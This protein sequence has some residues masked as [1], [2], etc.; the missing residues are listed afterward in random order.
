MYDVCFYHALGAPF[1]SQK[2]R[3]K[4]KRERERKG[5][6]FGRFLPIRL[7]YCKTDGRLSGGGWV[8]LV[9]AALVLL[10][11]TAPRSRW[12][13]SGGG[14]LPLG[15][16]F[17]AGCPLPCPCCLSQWLLLMARPWLRFSIGGY[18]GFSCPCLTWLLVAPG[19]PLTFPQRLR[20]LPF[21]IFYFTT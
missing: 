12:L 15:V 2:E 3:R 10:S 16:G 8:V 4:R 11:P 20:F 1:T 7:K 5:L 19:R 21:V 6:S 9:W 17:G 13:A 14:W 18:V